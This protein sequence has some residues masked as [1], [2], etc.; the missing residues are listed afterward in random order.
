[1]NSIV[2]HYKELALKGRNRPWFVQIL[3]RNLKTALSGLDVV[4]VRSMM[5]RI[6][7]ELGRNGSWSEA[8]DRIRHVFGIANFSWAGRAAHDFD[9]LSEAIVRDVGDRRP[10][11]FRVR[12]RRS[13][14]RFAF[15]SP[16]IEREVGGR[17]KDR[18]GWHV[19][20][21]A[22]DLSI[23][24]EMLPE[25]AFYY[26]GKEPGAG[27]LPSGTGG[28]VA[29]AVRVTVAVR[30]RVGGAVTVAVFEGVRV[31]VIVGVTV[32]VRVEVAVEVAVA[33]RVALRVAVR[34]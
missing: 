8:R 29:V 9:V 32:G 3:V 17:I 1:M 13:D 7:V 28:K 5:G 25:H 19:D 33:V 30:V 11:S 16:Q 34:F 23:H 14:K 2:V 20:L 22:P 4:A 31:W 24:V 21:E 27:G 10:Q 12:A 26:F 15:T 18:M 6:E